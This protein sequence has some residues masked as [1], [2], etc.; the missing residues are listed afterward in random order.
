MQRA[1]AIYGGVDDGLAV[2]GRGDVGGD[3][4]CLTALL[5]DDGQGLLGRLGVAVNQ[6]DASA[7]AGEQD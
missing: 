6:E 5:V 3:Y 4:R 1:V 2:G 7:V